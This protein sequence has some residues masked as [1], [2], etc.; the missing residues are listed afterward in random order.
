MSA[1]EKVRGEMHAEVDE[2]EPALD[3]ARALERI[4]GDVVLLAEIARLFM[5]E[6]PMLVGQIRRACAAGDS[7]ELERAA[8]SLKGAA[9][10]FSAAAT[11]HAA[12][13]LERMARAGDLSQASRAIEL[14]EAELA[15]VH[16]ELVRLAE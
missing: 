4:G 5:Q 6:Y 8:H 15:R 16:P 9:A 2:A 1:E 13:M 11:V 12:L 3:R 14:L 10:N 7:H